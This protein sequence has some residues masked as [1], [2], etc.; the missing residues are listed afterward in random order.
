[1]CE[2]IILKVLTVWEKLSETRRGDFLDSHSVCIHTQNSIQI[3]DTTNKHSL[4]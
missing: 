4:H 2:K 1:V 3:N